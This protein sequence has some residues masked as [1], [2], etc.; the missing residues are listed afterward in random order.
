VDAGSPAAPWLVLEPLDQ[1]AVP[2]D[3]V[4]L[5]A[6]ATGPG[7][8]FYQWLFEG[9]PLPGATNPVLRLPQAE[10]GQAGFYQVVVTNVAGAF[11]SRRALLRVVPPGPAPML[12]G[13]APQASVN[14]DTPLGLRFAIADR[15][16]PLLQLVVNATSSNPAVVPAGGLVVDGS[17]FQRTL[18]IHPATNAVGTTLLT[19]TATDGLYSV[20]NTVLLTVHPVN[21]PPS[22]DPIADVLVDGSGN[23]PAQTITLS[24]IGP[25]PGNETGTVQVVV[26]SANPALVN[27]TSGTYAGAG[28]AGT[29]TFDAVNRAAGTALIMV[30]VNDGAA[31][32]NI[33]SRSFTAYYHLGQIPPTIG[34]IPSPT[35]SED[36]AA[37]PLGFTVGDATTPAASLTLQAFSSNPALIPPQR[38]TFGGSGSNR[39][40]TLLPEP[41]QSGTASVRVAVIDGGFAFAATTFNFVVTP[42]NDRPTLLAPGTQRLPWNGISGL[43]PVQV[44]DKE[45]TADRLTLTAFCSNTNLIPAAGLLVGGQGTNRALTLAPASNQLGT[46]TITLRVEDPQGGVT[47]NSFLVEVSAT[48]LPPTLNAPS[49]VQ[50]EEDTPSTLVTILLADDSTIPEGLALSVVSSNA[51]LL[52]ADRVSLG[53]TGAQRTLSL[54]PVAERSGQSLITLTATDS[55]GASTVHRLLAVVRPVNDPPTLATPAALTLMA[56]SAPQPVALSGIG[57]GDPFESQYL[58]ITASSLNPAVVPHPSVAYQSPNASGELTLLAKSPGTAVIEVTVA[59]GGRTNAFT[60]RQFVVTVTPRLVLAE[61]PDQFL[62][63][64]AISLP[65]SLAASGG[66]GSPDDCVFSVVSSDPTL[67]PASGLLLAGTGGTR[68]L[69]LRPATNQFGACVVTVTVTDALTNHAARSFVVTVAPINDPPELATLPDLAVGED[70]GNHSVTLAGLRTG[71]PNEGGRLSINATTDRPDLITHPSVNHLPQAPTGTLAFACLPDATGTAV[72]SV[73]VWDGEAISGSIT[74]SFR[75]ILVPGNDPPSFAPVPSQTLFEDV[76]LLVPLLVRDPDAESSPLVVSA[77]CS[78]PGLVPSDGLVVFGDGEERSLRI[79]PA[80]NRAGNAVITL[81]VADAAGATNSTH[82][83]IQV[84]ALNDPPILLLAPTASNILGVVSEELPLILMDPE[85]PPSDLQLRAT[86]SNPLLLPDT[87]ITFGGTGSNRTVRLSPLPLQSGTATITFTARDPSGAETTTRLV[88]SV[89]AP[90]SPPYISPIPDVAMEENQAS[91]P[92]SF[93]VSDSESASVN[94]VLSAASSNPSLLPAS[95]VILGGSS[96]NRN[97]RLI[98]LPNRWGVAQVTVTVTDGSGLSSSRTFQVTVAEIPDPPVIVVPPRGLKVRA[99]ASAELE[100][101]ASG[102]APL[103]YQWLRE[104]LPVP[105]ATNR[106]LTLAPVQTAD[107]GNYRVRVSNP[108]G[109]ATSPAALLEVDPPLVIATVTQASSSLQITFP[110]QALRRYVVEY[111]LEANAGAWQTLATLDGT[112]NV[113]TVVDANPAAPRRFYRV[114]ED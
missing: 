4:Q 32:N 80:T 71:P 104:G 29:I 30:T 42:V 1:D 61:I 83:N 74:Q 113:V 34:P 90:I 18:H 79:T 7:P 54:N 24:G 31:S 44:A 20:T 52:P 85:S 92:V 101:L 93:T 72:V 37:G 59:D 97:L 58:S 45:A 106:I 11:S 27:S 2:G 55:A 91:P 22:L 19:V 88:F 28:S 89:N 114:R 12:T 57:D 8:V 70:S 49:Y 84:V 81:S 68:T 6:Q 21:D 94:L 109:S 69:T 108:V 99:G 111:R 13:L 105:G 96:T 40:V 60:S 50:L 64:D 5:I 76:T 38:I 73:V 77:T 63:E 15:D 112:G 103:G 86:S 110:S 65:V 23:P 48:N 35:I 26:S 75:V 98:P 46:A 107:A 100:V 56:G 53:G 47:S 62:T 78:D 17:G 51:T 39:T 87:A 41:D 95:Q 10:P 3:E 43:I 33:S 25:G 66:S 102:G 9:Q 16:T 14:E 36:S 67:L 82:F